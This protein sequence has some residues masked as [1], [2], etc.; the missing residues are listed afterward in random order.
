MVQETTRNA[1]LAPMQNYEFPFRADVQG[2]RG[3]AVLLVVFY[4]CGLPLTGGFVGV[5][6]FFV[7]SGFVITGGLLKALSGDRFSPSAFFGRRVKRLLPA[8]ALL[9]TTTLLVAPWLSPIV[10]Q[11]RT[12]ATGLAATFISANAYLLRA[13][14]YFE[15]DAE[16]NPFLHTWSLSVEEQ[17]YL[18]FP[19]LLAGLWWWG[20]RRGRTH[21]TVWAG[22]VVVFATSL[23]GCLLAAEI[24]GV[25]G[26]DWLRVSFFA[27]PTRAW[28]FALGALVALGTAGTAAGHTGLARARH[29]FAPLGLFLIVGPAFVYSKTTVFPGYAALLPVVGTAMLLVEPGVLRRAFSH[30]SVTWLG[31]ISYAWYLWHWPL[32]VC[33]R[34]TFPDQFWA[35]PAAVVLSIAFAVISYRWFEEPIRSSRLHPALIGAVCVVVPS[36]AWYA[37]GVVL[38]DPHGTDMIAALRIENQPH[39][40]RCATGG[41]LS[42]PACQF[43][44][45]GPRVALVGDS[46][47][48]QHVPA[49]QRLAD[50]GVLRLSVSTLLGC[51]FMEVRHWRDGQEH[52]RCHAWVQDTT[53]ALLRDRPDVVVLGLAT[54]AYLDQ[55]R[56]ALDHPIHG[57]QSDPQTKAEA[58]SHGLQQTISAL[59]AG[60]IYVVLVDPIPKFVM[61]STATVAGACS[62][63][64]VHLFPTVCAP[65]RGLSDS[66]WH[67]AEAARSVHRR[68]SADRVL[69]LGPQLCALGRCRMWDGEWLYHDGTHLSRAGSLRTVQTFRDA[70]VGAQPTK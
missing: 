50:E 40:R 70:I 16:Q 7:I 59:Q 24:R 51:P 58:A 69:D 36:A 19:A 64:G 52:R 68:T 46:N 2:L 5:D 26:I 33:F 11:T 3:L 57:R 1:R 25:A 32:L 18:V 4:H 39:A 15:G 9:V 10:S 67:N 43:G 29:W 45:A 6:V 49:L 54:D 14:G 47:A 37:N 56:F 41:R 66:T 65:E 27:S 8:L 22:V 28:E 61:G 31:D 63:A 35:V 30:R 44:V 21:Q 12:S 55:E 53:E 48:A 13:G 23:L 34:A 60:G 17:F 38:N 42:D 20:Q 62:A